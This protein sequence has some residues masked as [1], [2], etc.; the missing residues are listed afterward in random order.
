VTVAAL[1]QLM[2]EHASLVE[3]RKMGTLTN[4]QR[5]RLDLIRDVLLEA[6]MGL[7]AEIEKRPLRAPRATVS[8]EVTFGERGALAR[9]YS[10]DIGTGGIA[11]VT[12]QA[13]PPGTAVD[14]QIQ[15][16]GW[17]KPLTASGVVSWKTADAMG[18]AFRDIKADDDTRLKELLV[19]GTSFLKRILHRKQGQNEPVPAKVV[20]LGMVSLRISDPVLAGVTGELL[21]LNGYRPPPAGTGPDLIVADAH[22]VSGAVKNYPTVPVILVNVTGPEE[23]VGSLKEL[24]PVGFVAGPPTAAKVLE[25]V[26][27]VL[28]RE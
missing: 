12:D 15:A 13:L 18:I 10:R 20:R 23:L 6:G 22:M 25:M 2:Q 14:L 17:E 19:E 28:H 27:A 11:I 21:E 5:K 26:R 3:A 7:E 16:P 9:A 4:D 1:E 8:L 24:K